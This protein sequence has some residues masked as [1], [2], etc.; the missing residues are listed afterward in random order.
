MAAASA[1]CEGEGRCEGARERGQKGVVRARGSHRL[2]KGLRERRG[3]NGGVNGFNAI[4]DGVRLRGV[5]EG[6]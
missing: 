1:Q 3:G 5:E 6:P 4:E 2:L